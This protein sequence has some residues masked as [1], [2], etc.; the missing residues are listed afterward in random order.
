MINVLLDTNVL[1]DV[2]L[3]K[4]LFDTQQVIWK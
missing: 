4:I 3:V 2:L 1:L